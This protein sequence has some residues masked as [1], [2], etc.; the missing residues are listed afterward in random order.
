MIKETK[1]HYFD[2]LNK[3]R[4]L[5]YRIERLEKEREE[6]NRQQEDLI[7]GPDSDEWDLASSKT[8]SKWGKEYREKFPTK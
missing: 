1:E 8:L 4:Y 3:L 6:L 5:T 7:M 2:R